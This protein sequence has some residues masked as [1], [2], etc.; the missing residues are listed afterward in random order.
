LIGYNKI[1]QYKVMNAEIN[2]NLVNDKISLE[3]VKG[4]GLDVP[5]QPRG[6]PKWFKE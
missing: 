3:L 2:K 4:S 1:K 5:P 6:M